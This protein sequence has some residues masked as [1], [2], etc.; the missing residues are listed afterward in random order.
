MCSHSATART[1]RRGLLGCR[2]EFIG[3][4]DF[5]KIECLGCGHVKMLTAAM[6]RSAG[7]SQHE[8]IRNLPR[9]LRCR[10]CDVKGKAEVSIQ[11]ADNGAGEAS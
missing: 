4:R 11:G 9:R 3:P 6:L 10:E 5:V 8:Q 2:L 1:T 7:A